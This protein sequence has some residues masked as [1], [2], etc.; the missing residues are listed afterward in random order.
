MSLAVAW[1]GWY[2]IDR[3][4]AA[5]RRDLDSRPASL[6]GI[7]GWGGGRGLARGGRIM[8]QS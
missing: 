4:E 1:S 6:W 7:Y 8:Q 3:T 2:G 5:H